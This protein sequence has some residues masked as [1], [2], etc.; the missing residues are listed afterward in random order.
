MNPSAS[1]TYIEQ[2]FAGYKLVS[3]MWCIM[4]LKARPNASDTIKMQ[5]TSHRLLPP[6]KVSALTDLR[7]SGAKVAGFAWGCKGC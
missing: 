1:E 6:P 4:H 5:T 7:V 2:I 3:N